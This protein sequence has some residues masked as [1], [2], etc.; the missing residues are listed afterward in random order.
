MK[1][2]KK[3]CSLIDSDNGYDNQLLA[4]CCENIADKHAIEFSV[5]THSLRTDCEKG[6]TE[7]SKWENTS[8]KELLEIYKKEKGL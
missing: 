1:L 6:I 4:D 7:Y 5:W 8:N 2:N 3:Y